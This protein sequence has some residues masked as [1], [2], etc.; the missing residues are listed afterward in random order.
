MRQGWPKPSLEA[1]LN[2]ESTQKS[3]LLKIYAK[4]I[5][6]DDRTEEYKS[7]DGGRQALGEEASHRLSAIRQKCPE[8]FDAL[9]RRLEVTVGAR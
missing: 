7:P 8:D 6:I 9:A 1:P 2:R 3:P 5:N 4:N